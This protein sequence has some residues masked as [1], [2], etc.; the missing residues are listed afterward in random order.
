MRL[1][2]LSL[3]LPSLCAAQALPI[4]AQKID[5]DEGGFGGALDSGDRFGRSIV[6]IGDLDGDGVTEAV[7]N[8][9][10]EAADRPA[11]CEPL[12]TRRRRTPTSRWGLPWAPSPPP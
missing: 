8:R 1:P 9:G 2:V 12:E 11:P 10:G 7:G 6:G 4:A 3:P 5:S